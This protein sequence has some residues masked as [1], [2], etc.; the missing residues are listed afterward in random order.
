MR[1]VL[2]LLRSKLQFLGSMIRD[3]DFAL[4]FVVLAFLA[5]GLLVALFVFLVLHRA[6]SFLLAIDVFGPALTTYTLEA[7]FALVFLLLLISGVSSGLVIFFRSEEL[8]FLIPHPIRTSLL[9]LYGFSKNYLISS[10]PVLILGI[11]AVISLGMVYHES[12]F[13]YIAALAGII[14][15]SFGTILLGSILTFL[16]GFILPRINRLYLTVILFILLAFSGYLFSKTLVPVNFKELFR[17][18]LVEA[19]IVSSRDIEQNFRYWPSHL[20]V[21]LLRSFIDPE[22]GIRNSTAPWGI[23]VFPIFLFASSI[24][25]LRFYLPLWAKLQETPFIAGEKNGKGSRGISI[26]ISRILRGET[27]IIIEKDLAALLRNFSNLTSLGFFLFLL[28]V[29]VSAV[30]GIVGRV[31]EDLEPKHISIVIMLTLGVVGYFAAILSLRFVFPAVSEEGKSAWVT[32]TSPF[33][34]PK[35]IWA[36]FSLYGFLFFILLGLVFLLSSRVLVGDPLLLA[37]LAGVVFTE[38]AAITAATLSLGTLFPNF[39]YQDV[40]RLSTTPGGLAATFLSIGY[41]FLVMLLLKQF[42]DAYL[43][44]MKILVWPLAVMSLGSVLAV[45]FSLSLALKRIGYIR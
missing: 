16:L 26:P 33:P 29:Y 24:I 21:D 20:Y 35:I 44:D 27:G 28:L 23:L 15:F 18:E 10:W 36:K 31:G 22:F 3:R 4:A 41:I 38:V 34:L 17:A 30:L 12:S 2:S 8:V 1:L 19:E 45:W 5:L 9:F 43:I 13:F 14:V 11:P 25:S 42:L 32:W 7:S 6:F 37:I 39:H 40:E